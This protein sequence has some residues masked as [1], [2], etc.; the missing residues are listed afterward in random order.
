M[1]EHCEILSHSAKRKGRIQLGNHLSESRSLATI[2]KG[3]YLKGECPRIDAASFFFLLPS[4]H[5]ISF[6]GPFPEIRGA[7]W[8]GGGTPVLALTILVEIYG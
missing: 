8:G 3:G 4:G 2:A 5:F 6:S 1:H 7:G